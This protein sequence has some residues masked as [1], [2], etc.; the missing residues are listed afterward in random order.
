[1]NRRVGHWGRRRVGD[2]TPTPAG[3][4]P[5]WLWNFE[6]GANMRQD[7]IKGFTL[8]GNLGPVNH[9]PTG[10]H[11]NCAFVQASAEYLISADAITEGDW[12]CALWFN[13]ENIDTTSTIRL[14]R[15]L[16]LGDQYLNVE[17]TD[18]VSVDGRWD[19]NV[20]WDGGAGAQVM[21]FLTLEGEWT[22]VGVAVTGGDTVR[23]VVNSGDSGDPQ[24][25]SSATSVPTA[26]MH[27]QNL[28]TSTFQGDEE[29]YYDHLAIWPSTPLTQDQMESQSNGLFFNSETRVW[30]SA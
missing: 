8:E 28:V 27:F 12:S 11:G 22:Y 4:P 21:N 30:E 16:G 7:S 23:A 1:M 13:G 25:S 10:R 17:L 29:I 6:N 5:F 24:H 19:I 20:R 9:F 14:A 3:E 15:F 26:D 2:G 18:S